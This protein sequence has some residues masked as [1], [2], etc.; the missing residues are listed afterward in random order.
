[1]TDKTMEKRL[2]TFEDTI[3]R[4]VNTY[5]VGLR[6]DHAGLD[7]DDCIA[8]VREST[9]DLLRQKPEAT[10]GYVCRA[11]WNRVRDLMRTRSR[12]NAAID[13]FA[14]VE[15][16]GYDP[17]ATVECHVDIQKA[18]DLLDPAEVQAIYKSMIIG[19]SSRLPRSHYTALGYQSASAYQRLLRQARERVKAALAA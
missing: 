19:D 5:G 2:A 13:S 12:H 9:W 14:T 3:R 6:V 17:M 18:L 4:A 7:R 15:D 10:R 8:I 11:I 16:R 1:M